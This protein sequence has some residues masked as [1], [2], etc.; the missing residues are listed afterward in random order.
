MAS[1]L[2]VLVVIFTITAFYLMYEQ[3]IFFSVRLKP[4]FLLLHLLRLDQ[5]TKILLNPLLFLYRILAHQQSQI[6]K[7]LLT[8]K[9][10]NP[11]T[12]AEMIVHQ[13]VI[14]RS[15]VLRSEQKNIT[16]TVSGR[17]NCN[18]KKQLDGGNFKETPQKEE[19][20]IY[21]SSNN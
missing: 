4:I 20:K 21:Y 16:L 15:L 19:M 12:S 3:R 18:Y 2:L 6:K 9:K 11:E 13:E 17:S 7:I 1:F 14:S 5:F 8:Q 10:F